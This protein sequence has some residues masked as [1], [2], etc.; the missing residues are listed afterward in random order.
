ME[1]G[2]DPPRARRS[3][4]APR[5]VDPRGRR[6][7]DSE[8]RR[9]L[10]ERCNVGDH[11]RRP[12]GDGMQGHRAERAARRA[13]PR[14]GPRAHGGEPRAPPEDR[15][16]P[17]GGPRD[18]A[19]RGRG[20]DGRGGREGAVRRRGQA[21]RGIREAGGEEGRGRPRGHVDG[22]RRDAPEGEGVPHA[23]RGR[24]C[25]AGGPPPEG[26]LRRGALRDVDLP[27]GD[28]VPGRRVRGGAPRL[29]REGDP[30]LRAR[31]PGPPVSY[32]SGRGSVPG[33][34]AGCCRREVGHRT[35]GD[36]RQARDRGRMAGGFQRRL[37]PRP[38]IGDGTQGSNHRGGPHGRPCERALRTRPIEGKGGGMKAWILSAGEGTRM[39][40][41]T[42]NLPKPLLP[43]AGKPFLAHTIEALRDAGVTELAV[44]IGWQ[45]R[46]VKEYF[47]RGDAFGVKL[48]YEEQ[49]E[50]LGTAHAIGMAR[51]HVSG[52]FLSVNGDVVF[53]AKAVK[54]LLE[55][56]RKAKGPVMAVAEVENP[57][58]FGVAEL[59]G[60]RVVGL[61][62]KPKAPKSNL[63]N[64][65]VYLFP[66]DVFDFIDRT[67]KSSRGEYEITDTIRLLMAYRDVF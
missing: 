20:P 14:E 38:P 9:G 4:G 34:R 49:A 62:E 15:P 29:H 51:E 44:L 23:G 32:P 11:P 22:D 64:A 57:A 53:S 54:G 47:G 6:S 63:I 18:R 1:Q 60:D 25:R 59:D 31:R 35:A 30:A 37:V 36:R 28:D 42:A 24:V 39:R 16:R 21:P 67:P 48:S 43:V 66:G 17:R 7:C 27:E 41:L 19:R 58:A 61:E 33:W 2:R 45:G 13:L 10:R 56:H 5:A 3:R 8:G 26:G 40:P 55:F 12:E 50:R 52:D 46:R 65:G